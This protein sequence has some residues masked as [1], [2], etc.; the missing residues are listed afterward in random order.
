MLGRMDSSIIPWVT[1]PELA[2]WTRE[3]IDPED[4]WANLVVRAATIKVSDATEKD[5]AYT[6]DTAPNG[7]KVIVAQLAMRTYKNPD[8]IIRE[9]SIGPI[10]GDAYAQAYAAGLS[11]TEEELLEVG[12]LTRRD[13]GRT[14]KGIKVLGF[15]VPHNGRYGRDG[16]YAPDTPAPGLGFSAGSD[17]Q[18]PVD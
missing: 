7:L 6:V 15:R 11:L 9:G 1:V 5:P 16:T 14:G 12:R 13:G 8:Q 10:G 2:V 3:A 17:W 18:I 4:P